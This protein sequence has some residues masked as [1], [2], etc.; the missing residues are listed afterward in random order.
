MGGRTAVKVPSS[1]TVTEPSPSAS[2]SN[3]S[4][5]SSAR[6]TS[7]I[8]STGRPGAVVADAAQDRTLD[9]ELLAEE[10]RLRDPLV[11]RLGHPDGEQ[12]TLV[13]P[14]VERLA[15]SQALVALEPHERRVQGLGE[16]LRGGRLADPGLTLEQQRE[17]EPE[18]QEDRRRHPFVGE[19]VVLVEPP[20]DLLG[21][22]QLAHPGSSSNAW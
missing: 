16:G 20:A 10:V 4:N 5:S 14:V 21:G 2:S 9:E 19:V 18:R 12:L 15:R 1:G 8:S 7:S 3:A 17:A 22:G 13:V 11:L 6:S